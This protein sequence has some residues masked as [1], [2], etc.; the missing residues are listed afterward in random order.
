ML[1]NHHALLPFSACL[2]LLVLSYEPCAAHEGV[3][4]VGYIVWQRRRLPI[5]VCWATHPL[6]GAT[7]GPS[8]PALGGPAYTLRI[9]KP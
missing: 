9:F 2:H 3:H 8:C 5:L 4:A 1:C 7:P 6:G